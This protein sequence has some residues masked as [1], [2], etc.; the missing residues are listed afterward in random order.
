[1]STTA[2]YATLS[3]LIDDLSRL[4]VSEADSGVSLWIQALQQ[5]IDELRQ[6]R[7]K[8]RVFCADSFRDRYENRYPTSDV[9]S[10]PRPSKT[11][12]EAA[13]LVDQ[14]SRMAISNAAPR[15][16]FV[17]KLNAVRE[18]IAKL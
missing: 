7:Y 17:E 3:G 18:G 1:M 4:T 16:D 2:E 10:E 12:A 11:Q 6:D 13:Q 5:K 14:L 15:H 8:C 9:R